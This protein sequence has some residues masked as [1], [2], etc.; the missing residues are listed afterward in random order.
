MFQRPSDIEEHS[1]LLDEIKN[2]FHLR[3]YNYIMHADIKQIQAE[4]SRAAEKTGI[5]AGKIYDFLYYLKDGPIENN[6]LLAKTGI[7]K[8]ALN[9]L[10][11][12]LAGWL[13]PAGAKTGLG[14]KG[15]E[16]LATA[17]IKT[18]TENM[19]DFLK[20]T[21]SYKNAIALLLKYK[22][23]RVTPKREYDQFNA[24]PEST[25]LRCALLE[26][27]GDIQGKR[28]LFLGD[29]DFTSVS[30]AVT[31]SPGRIQVLDIDEDIMKNL[32]K[33][34]KEETLQ[35]SAERY[36]ARNT[37]PKR[38]VGSFDTVFTDPPYTTAGISLFLSRAVDALDRSNKS[39]RIYL[40]YG[41]SDLAKERFLP[42]YEA[43]IRSGLMLRW[44]FDKFNRYSGAE[45]IGSAS[46]L[47]ICE[48]TPKTKP[49]IKGEY[50]ENIFTA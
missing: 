35:I 19:H 48:T 30:L 22:N 1:G 24:T 47:F 39:A 31:H 29:D 26:F 11:S 20:E 12:E 42:I 5:H 15:K 7:A 50:A 32:S 13:S 4:I 8:N 49:L 37:L 27:V 45:A 40:C 33:I 2:F 44:V 41:N 6:L 34:A 16:V 43:I 46:T 23:L 28:L 17:E 38:Y 14:V 21:E 9:L 36:D 3:M 25:A 18:A 10:K